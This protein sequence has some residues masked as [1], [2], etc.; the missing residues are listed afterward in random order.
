MNTQALG[1]E[2]YLTGMRAGLDDLPPNEVAE[3]M[4]DVEAH[5]AELSSELGEN[6]TLEQR[7]GPPEQYAQE[8]RQ[9]AGYPPRTER[10]PVTTKKQLLTRPR[11]AAWGLVGATGVTLLAGAAAL[12]E[13]AILLL[14]AV[15]LVLS[16]ALVND[17][18][19]AQQEIMNLPETIRLK[20]WLTPE[21]GTP[22]ERA[23]TYLRSLQPAWWL[24][25]AGL[26]GLGAVLLAGRDIL[27]FLAIAAVAVVSVF[28]GPR[29]KVDRRWLW[30]S[31]PASALAVGLLFQVIDVTA[32]QLGYNA[33]RSSY[34]GPVMETYDNIYVY[35]E[36]GKLLSNV[37]LYDQDGQPINARQ[38]YS[39]CYDSDNGPEPVIPANRYPRPKVAYE[40]GRCY[41]VEPTVTAPSSPSSA[42]PPSSASATPSSVPPTSVS[43]SK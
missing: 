36:N 30:F 31:L 20:K 24:V 40:N 32:G 33:S 42:E 7:L 23:I 39:S 37:T 29:A 26:L 43:P 5:I 34:S 2:Y 12:R 13:P 15:I 28:A 10:L 16:L 3:I 22:A 41:T 11:A 17:R 6:E 27:G 4:E 19:P 38:G 25:R 9:A 8:L 18:G 21:P 35:D 1:V 14:P